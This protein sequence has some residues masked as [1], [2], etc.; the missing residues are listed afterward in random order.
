MASLQE[1][2]IKAGLVDKSKANKAKKERQKQANLARRSKQASPSEA[3]VLARQEKEMRLARER[4][5]NRQKQEASSRK[6]IIAQ[7]RQLVESNKLDRA[8]GEITYSY[9]YRG[10]I[11]KIIVTEELKKQLTRGNLAIVT[12]VTSS[13]R[14]FEIVPAVVAEKIAQRDSESVILLNEKTAEGGND[15]DPYADYQ[16]P[17]DLTW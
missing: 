9:A 12:A 1:Q 15:D 3:S 16:V 13:N 4:E 5:L 6:A 7:V 11:K 17:D 2:L 14:I 8:Q 10:K